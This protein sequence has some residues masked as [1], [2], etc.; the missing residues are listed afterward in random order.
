VDVDGIPAVNT[1]RA[2]EEQMETSFLR[3]IGK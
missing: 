3:A 1:K 2:L